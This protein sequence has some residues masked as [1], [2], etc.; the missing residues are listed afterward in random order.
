[1]LEAGVAIPSTSPWFSP[2][3]LLQ[4]TDAF[5]N[6]SGHRIYEFHV[7][8]CGLCQDPGVCIAAATFTRL[9]DTESTGET[10]LA[11]LDDIIIFGRSWD[12]HL[13]RLKQVVS[14]VV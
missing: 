7:L 8:P 9:M 3:I 5:S 4:K 14:Y 2:I 11:F 13:K 10:C 12:E 1:M 6:S